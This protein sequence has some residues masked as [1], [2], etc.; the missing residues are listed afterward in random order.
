MFTLKHIYE[1][2]ETLHAGKEPRLE[3]KLST[4]AMT[5]PDYGHFEV[6]YLNE[7]DVR[8]GLCGGV[9]YVMNDK[10]A[11]VAKYDLDELCQNG[12]LSEVSRPRMAN[13]G[14]VGLSQ[15]PRIMNQHAG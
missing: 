11:T 12:R 3:H 14:G 1:S 6:S 4:A 5:V 7:H 15:D 9:V 10:G 13:L 8:L 2:G